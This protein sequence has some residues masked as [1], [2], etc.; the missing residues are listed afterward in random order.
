MS[1]YKML[2]G[3][4]EGQGKKLQE[5]EVRNREFS[6]EQQRIQAESKDKLAKLQEDLQMKDKKLQEAKVQIG[7]GQSLNDDVKRLQGEIDEFA[8]KETGLRE[9][10][11]SEQESAKKLLYMEQ[12]RRR[13]FEELVEKQ[14]LEIE[15]SVAEFRA[16]VKEGAKKLDV[17][18]ARLRFAEENLKKEQLSHKLC[19]EEVKKFGSIYR[20][21]YEES[22]KRVTEL[23][24]KEEAKGEKISELK[25]RVEFF[26]EIYE[27]YDV[28]NMPKTLLDLEEKVEQAQSE[29]RKK[30][31]ELKMKVLTLK[32]QDKLIDDLNKEINTIRLTQKKCKEDLHK[33]EV[34]LENFTKEYEELDSLYKELESVASVD[35]GELESLKVLEKKILNLEREKLDL[36]KRINDCDGAKIEM[37]LLLDEYGRKEVAGILSTAEKE[38]ISYNPQEEEKDQ[39]SVEEEKISEKNEDVVVEEPVEQHS[40]GSDGSKKENVTS[41][42]SAQELEGVELAEGSKST[43]IKKLSGELDVS[44]ATNALKRLFMIRRNLLAHLS[45][46]DLDGSI[47]DRY[48]AYLEDIKSYLGG[49]LKVDTELWPEAVS[50]GFKMAEYISE[51]LGKGV[52]DRQSLLLSEEGQ[53]APGEKLYVFLGAFFENYVLIVDPPL[54]DILPSRVVSSF[55]CQ[56]S[57]PSQAWCYYWKNLLSQIDRVNENS[58]QWLGYID[59]PELLKSRFGALL[60]TEATVL[61]RVIRT[62]CQQIACFEAVSYTGSVCQRFDYVREIVKKMKN[63][64]QDDVSSLYKTR[65]LIRNIKQYLKN[66]LQPDE[67]M[68]TATKECKID[69]PKAIK[70]LCSSAKKVA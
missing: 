40:K 47:I 60:D 29:V 44:G 35:Q 62:D 27:G 5:L 61:E 7:A 26:D 55:K 68:C 8:S 41:K 32:K 36:E 56:G 18:R 22:E 37:Q 1:L 58:S 24:K 63:I 45:K 2:L 12:G 15:S 25:S 48:R 11:R 43:S 57:K 13:E 64:I 23:L 21:M 39:P 49:G 30:G 20:P 67:K 52:P 50:Y 59:R 65:F 69:N 3:E 14:K 33:K 70:A 28:E 9:Q 66:V 6:E 17:I 51:L 38:E 54:Y 16:W 34:E 10:L 31:V 42:W 46:K 53:L 4:K 19:S